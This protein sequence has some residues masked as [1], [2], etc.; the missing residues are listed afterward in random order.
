LEHERLST[1]SNLNLDAFLERVKSVAS[2]YSREGHPMLL[3]PNYRDQLSRLEMD[4]D[5][6][7][8]T[9]MRMESTIMHGHAPG[10]EASIFKLYQSELFQK[11]CDL[12][13]HAMGPDAIDWY[14]PH[15]SQN[16]YAWPMRM[17]ITRAM[18]IYSGS[19]EIQ[20]NIIAKRVLA[21]PD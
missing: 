8:Y 17:T 16:A 15:L 3:D 9:R 18:S 11:V 2:E 6:L 4:A 1:G 10:H 14:D 5:C 7:R 12:A 20:R 13:L 21:L 19:N